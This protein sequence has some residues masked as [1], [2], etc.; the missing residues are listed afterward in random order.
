MFSHFTHQKSA[1]LS[2]E[3]SHCQSLYADDPLDS[4]ST[5]ETFIH[6]PDENF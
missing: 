3:I 2:E 1:A 5:S 4:Q 6:R